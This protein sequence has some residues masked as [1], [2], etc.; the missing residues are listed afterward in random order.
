MD[1]TTPLRSQQT[2]FIQRLKSGCLLHCEIQGQHSEL[3]VISGERLQ[4]LR[5]FCW[6][7][8]DKYK[9][10]SSVR[11]VFIDN[12]KGKLAEEVVQ[13][14][15][16]DLVTEVDYEKRI[17][18]DGKV[19]FRL[20]SDPAIG[21]QVKSR[22]GTIDTVQWSISKEEVE[23][24]AVLVCILIQEE[25]NEAQ[26]KHNLVTAGF[27]PTYLI[28]MSNSQSLLGINELLYSGGLRSY[29][30]NS[31][32]SETNGVQWQEIQALKFKED[33]ETTLNQN[34]Y[35]YIEYQSLSP[36]L[37]YFSIG[38]GCYKKGD[39]QN[40]IA[41]YNQAL[42]VN[43]SFAE[44]YSWRGAAYY[45]IGDNYKAIDDFNKGLGINP[46]NA[47]AH[48]NRGAVYADIG[49]KHSAIN[50]FN[51]AIKL[52]PNYAKAYYNRGNTHS[53]L[54]DKQGAIEDYTQ[55]VNINP[56]YAK[57]YY[58]RAVVRSTIGDKQRAIKDFEK[59]A[60]LFRQQ[61]NLDNYRQ[62]VNRIGR[63]DIVAG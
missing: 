60:D 46:N 27:L 8:V 26:A 15:L 1:W 5:D 30:G 38:I 45:A 9:R 56:N 24:N 61:D 21:L 55:A 63:F 28:N 2:D 34:K 44:A 47:I 29:L 52:N 16:I 6:E 54:G 58:D 4:Q 40:A 41:N 48:N 49:D 43:S 19:D 59:A 3:T 23:K 22:H 42:Q 39:Y 51:Q 62:A 25:V 37:D 20:N 7:M 36:V 50:N 14:R 33:C 18:G 12:M 53:E 31:K 35:Q 17:N 57:A 32:F 10:N 11:K 13:A